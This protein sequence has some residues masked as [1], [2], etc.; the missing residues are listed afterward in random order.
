MAQA[1]NTYTV[2]LKP[3]HLDWGEYRNPTNRE[4]ISGEG[5]IPIPKR[6]AVQYNIFNSNSNQI[7]LG[8]NLFRASSVDGFLQNVL[9][10]AQG[11][12]EAGDP[13]AKQF[14]VDN[15]L[16]L[17]GQWYKNGGA[18]TKNSVRVTWVSS[19]DIVLEIV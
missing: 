15:N 14:S 16:K 17:I 2:K 8:Y 5:Y 1:G 7:G 12:S 3:S 11:C 13:Y 19:T 6:Y 18:T 4:P 10:L 9:L